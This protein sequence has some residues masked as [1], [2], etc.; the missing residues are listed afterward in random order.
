MSS[1]EITTRVRP[2]ARPGR[3]TARLPIPPRLA[4][5]RRLPTPLRRL[6]KRLVRHVAH[7]RLRA[8]A[9][10]SEGVRQI[11]RRCADPKVAHDV[12]HVGGGDVADDTASPDD[13]GITRAEANRRLAAL[14]YS[15]GAARLDSVPRRLHVALAD[16]C[17]MRCIMCRVSTDAEEFA[18]HLPARV[19][20]ELR[21][22][23]PLVE[24]VSITG[25]EPFHHVTTSPVG[26]LIQAAD[27]HDGPS[28]VT[29][30][31]GVLLTDDVCQM[32]LDRFSSLRISVDSPY[33]DVY[34]SIRVRSSFRRIA[35]NIEHLRDLKASDGRER[36]DAPTLH[37][38]YLIMDRTFRGIVDFV[39]LAQTWQVRE[40][41]FSPLRVNFDPGLADE[42]IFTDVYKVIE[43]ADLM[44][45][46]RRRAGEYG[47]E[48]IDRTS[49]LVRDTLRTYGLLPAV[50]TRAPGRDRTGHEMPVCPAPWTDLWIARNGE[51]RFCRH[52]ATIGNV[53]DGSIGDVVNS[54]A[55]QEVR[56]RFVAGDY[57]SCKRGSCPRGIANVGTGRGETPHEFET[58]RVELRRRAA[59]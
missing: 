24:T 6:G 34:E 25:A 16:R 58:Q 48:I 37:I 39:D 55:A 57:S 45:E 33:A 52:G 41:R 38:N 56:R 19:H 7:R 20:T 13:I 40:I 15:T 47:I 5:A 54:E 49:R 17:N 3:P 28:F 43:Y 35:R 51:A 36:D 42:D 22:M 12:A 9:D 26:Q 10:A 8:V 23:L 1:M 21:E 4:W 32:V 44:A 30:T 18:S 53:L 29:T 27:P 2:P 11:R 59:G 14:E 50:G 46:A 31:N